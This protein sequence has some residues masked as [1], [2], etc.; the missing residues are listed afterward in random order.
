MENLEYRLKC[1]QPLIEDLI[2]S[3]QMGPDF[4]AQYAMDQLCLPNEAASMYFS[5]EQ[6]TRWNINTKPGSMC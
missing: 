2:G 4:A 1:A 3:H 5:T 6:G